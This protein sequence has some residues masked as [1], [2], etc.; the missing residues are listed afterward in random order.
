LIRFQLPPPDVLALSNYDWNTNLNLPVLKYVKQVNP[1]TITVLGGPN[2]EHSDYEWMTD[3]FKNRP[4]VDLYIVGEGEWSFTQLIELLIINEGK[5][6]KIPYDDWPATWYSFDK[7]NQ[8]VINNFTKPVERLDLSTVP[9]P[10]L[11]GILDP[12]LE[13]QRLAPIIETNRGCPYSCTFCCWGQATQSRVNQYPL[14][15]VLQEI[16]YVAQKCKNP[17][18]FFYIADGNFGILPRDLEIAKVLQDCTEKYSCPKRI[19]IYFAKNTNETVINIASTLKSVTSMSMSKQTLNEEALVNIKRKN[20]PPNQYDVLRRDCE[21]KGIDTFCELIYGLPGENYQSFVNGVIITVREKQK[22]TMYPHIMIAGAEANSREYRAKHGI[23]TAFRI[24]PRYVSS[25]GNIHSME[26]E[27]LIIETNDM[28]KEDFL[29]IR[30]F[31]FLVTFLGSKTFLEFAKSLRRVGS[32]Y[33]TLA[34][35]ITSDQENWTPHFRKLLTDFHESS[36]KELLS[37]DEIKIEFTEEDIQKASAHRAALIPFYMSTIASNNEFITDIQN[38]LSQAVERFFGTTI[39]S[40]DIR[41]LKV[42]LDLSFYKLICYANL[43]SEKI[44]LHNYDLDSWLASDDKIPLQNFYTSTPIPYRYY[45]DNDIIPNFEHLKS[46]IKDITEIVYRMRT[47]ILGITSDR[48]FCY[49]RKQEVKTIPHDSIVNKLTSD[50]LS[51][52]A[53]RL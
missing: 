41:E 19:Y 38:Y 48:I 13:D 12:F 3:F 14:E 2:F 22:V 37:K 34:N 26:Y 46:T 50:E 16:R 15:T 17:T 20:I 36:K 23:R 25:Y 7:E 52:L 32:D 21:K 49:N 35:L 43:H 10:Y 53:V 28:S 45:P 8:K 24:I 44:I 18:G 6:D 1:Q 9:S 40:T 30:L 33:A 27:E 51:Q 11:T 5:L 47:N 39:S 31:Q 29:R 42:A 4:Q